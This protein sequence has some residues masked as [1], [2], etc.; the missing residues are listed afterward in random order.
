VWDSILKRGIAFA[1]A[2]LGGGSRITSRQSQRLVLVLGAVLLVGAGLFALSDGL[3]LPSDALPGA[4]APGRSD[5]NE[6]CVTNGTRVT[7]QDHY[8]DISRAQPGT[9]ILLSAGTYEHLSVPAGGVGKPLTIKPFDCERVLI[10]GSL[11]V[12]SYNVI[13]GVEVEAPD[14]RWVMRIGSNSSRPVTDVTI[15]N[16]TIRGGVI[17][18]IRI[19]DNASRITLT[20]NDL[21]GG[22]DN[23]VVK[24]ASDEGVYHPHDITLSNNNLHKNYFRGSSTEDL[25]QA[26]GHGTVMLTGNIFGYNPGEDGVDI[27]TGTGGVTVVSNYFAGPQINAECVLVQGDGGANLIEGNYFNRSCTLSVGAHLDSSTAIVRH[28]FLVDSELRL[29]RSFGAQVV[30][31]TV[32][33]GTFTLGLEAD[34]QPRDVVIKNNLFLRTRVH[35]RTAA[36]SAYRCLQNIMSATSGD[37]LRCSSSAFGS[38]PR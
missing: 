2:Y 10:R 31:N 36:G 34:D 29:R 25:F 1:Q 5:T 23:H 35:D 19:V 3:V 20:G 27:K 9:T 7:P 13:A 24:V 12:S 15:R 33:S 26:E 4:S 21:D 14:N 16:S 32:V 22:R 8:S 37:E 30:D 17:D 6:P 38:A 11:E 28:N 18:A